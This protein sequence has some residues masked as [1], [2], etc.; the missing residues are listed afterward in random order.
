VPWEY[1]SALPDVMSLARLVSPYQPGTV[2]RAHGVRRRR[3]TALSAE[4]RAPFLRGRP[5][6]WGRRT[7]LRIQAKPCDADHPGRKR[8]Q[9]VERGEARV[10]HQDEGPLGQPAMELRE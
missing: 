5:L 6:V 4:S 8:C 1:Q 7:E 9:E 2:R 3:K 10:G